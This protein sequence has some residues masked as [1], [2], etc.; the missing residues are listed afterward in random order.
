MTRTLTVCVLILGLVACGG[1]GGS[2]DSLRPSVLAVSPASDSASAVVTT[3]VSATFDRVMNAST[4]DSLT[5]VVTEPPA[6]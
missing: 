3:N 1:F 4:T 2:D 5:A 6:T